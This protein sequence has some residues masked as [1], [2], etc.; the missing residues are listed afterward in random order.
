MKAGYVSIH[1]EI[2]KETEKAV[3]CCTQVGEAFNTTYYKWIPKSVCEFRQFV[4]TYNALGEPETY[5]TDVVAVKEW[6]ANK[7]HLY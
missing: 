7:E 6:F 4:A 3:Y 2:V 1:L 5:K